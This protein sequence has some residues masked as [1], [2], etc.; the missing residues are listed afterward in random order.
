MSTLRKIHIQRPWNRQAPRSTTTYCGLNARIT[1]AKLDK[2]GFA[3]AYNGSGYADVSIDMLCKTC[4]RTTKA[5]NGHPH[6]V[7]S[8]SY[9]DQRRSTL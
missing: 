2:Y 9:Y 1:D 8:Q 4:I 3:Y 6:H 5:R 7:R